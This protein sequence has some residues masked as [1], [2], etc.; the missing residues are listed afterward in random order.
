MK[1]LT[2]DLEQAKELYQSSSTKLKTIFTETFGKDFH[3]QKKDVMS[4]IKTFE[5]SASRIRITLIGLRL[6]LSAPAFALKREH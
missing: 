2:I 3:L 6:R 5:V 1:T 4:T